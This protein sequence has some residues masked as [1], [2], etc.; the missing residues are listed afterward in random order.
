MHKIACLP[1]LSATT[2]ASQN[3]CVLITMT[4]AKECAKRKVVREYTGY[5]VIHYRVKTIYKSS[6]NTIIVVLNK[7]TMSLTNVQ[8]EMYYCVP[9]QAYYY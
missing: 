7:L 2:A 3:P 9:F 6:I 8:R 1:Y 4:L 5:T